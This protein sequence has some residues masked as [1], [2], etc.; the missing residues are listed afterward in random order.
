MIPSRRTW[1]L[2]PAKNKESQACGIHHGGKTTKLSMNFLLNPNRFLR[3]WL[4]TSTA[5]TT[6]TCCINP[7]LLV[8][9]YHASV[10]FLC[11]VINIQCTG[12]YRL[13]DTINSIFHFCIFVAKRVISL[14]PIFLPSGK[15]FFGVVV[16]FVLCSIIQV[17]AVNSRLGL[18]FTEHGTV[19]HLVLTIIL[20]RTYCFSILWVK[21]KG[22]YPGQHQLA[23]M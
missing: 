7:V 1:F 13:R 11:S 14:Y 4:I 2:R 17:V 3:Q 5:Q 19:S 6:R 16:R 23:W 21:L 12:W 8:Y 15:M 22:K 20:W 10:T 18:I 9:F